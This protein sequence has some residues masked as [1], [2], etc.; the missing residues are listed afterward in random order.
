MNLNGLKYLFLGILFSCSQENKT[1]VTQIVEESTEIKVEKLENTIVK[2]ELKPISVVVVPCSNG[3][4][5]M[6]SLDMEID[7][8]LEKNLSK[9]K[10]IK[11]VSF[12]F[13]KMKGSGYYGVFD[14]KYCE[15]ILKN[16]EV[17]F[18][19]LSELRGGID[20]RNSKN[21]W[22]Y[23]IRIINTKTLEQINSI[24]GFK[25]KEHK[26]VYKN[27]KVKSEELMRDLVENK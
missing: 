9:F 22:G 11:V 14:K 24:S 26:D 10:E 12:P 18:L 19:I 3:Y 23:R 15:D 21:S 2:K 13:K 5:Y 27:I 16:V 6:L 1:K 17:D 7:S 25:M 8:H 20:L 4:E